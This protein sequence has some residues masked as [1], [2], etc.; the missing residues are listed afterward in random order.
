[1]WDCWCWGEIDRLYHSLI[2]VVSQV[3]MEVCQMEKLCETQAELQCTTEQVEVC[4]GDQDEDPEGEESEVQPCQLIPEEVC[5][6]VDVE[7]CR[8]RPLCREMVRTVRREICP[9]SE[10]N[11]GKTI[12]YMIYT[13]VYMLINRFEMIRTK[14]R[15]PLLSAI[16][17]FKPQFLFINDLSYSSLFHVQSVF[18]VP[19][20]IW[21]RSRHSVTESLNDS[22]F[23]IG[24]IN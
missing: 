9:D 18:R 22:F 2:S 12:L 7:K 5:S 1:M 21:F 19:S 20:S 17:M 13:Y 24:L 6:V 23:F 10:K 3:P 8:E 14:L 16:A 4:A 15:S 11:W